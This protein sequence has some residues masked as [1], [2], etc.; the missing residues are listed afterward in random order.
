MKCKAKSAFYSTLAVVC[1][2]P[3]CCVGSIMLIIG[4]I[5][6]DSTGRI[7]WN[8]LFYGLSVWLYTMA[9]IGA[10]CVVG[11]C[12]VFV[13]FMALARGGQKNEKCDKAVKQSLVR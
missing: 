4:S 3:C 9:T 1:S 5:F 11:S 8:P 6:G 10:I 13:V 7:W 12:V 2:L